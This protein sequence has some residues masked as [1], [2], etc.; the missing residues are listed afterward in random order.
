M[1]ESTISRLLNSK[2]IEVNNKNFPLKTFLERRVNN[3][4]KSGKD[5]SSFQLQENINLTINTEDR[6]SPLSD[7]K[8]RLKLKKESDIYVSRRTV[9]KYRKNLNIGSSRKRRS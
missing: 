5:I 3:K 2:Y 7:D 4:S 6:S 1:S 8:I 9:A